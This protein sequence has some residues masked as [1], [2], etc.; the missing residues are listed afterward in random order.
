MDVVS[1][2]ILSFLKYIFGGLE[3]YTWSCG[4]N[5]KGEWHFQ[6]GLEKKGGEKGEK[7]L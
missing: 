7:D 3:K 1:F 4:L 6:F 5:R 2:F